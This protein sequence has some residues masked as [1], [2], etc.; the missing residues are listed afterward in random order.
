MCPACGTNMERPLRNCPNPQS[1]VKYVRATLAAEQEGTCRV[2][3]EVVRQ[4][5]SAS[6]G[7]GTHFMYSFEAG[8]GTPKRKHSGRGDLE[9]VT[10]ATCVPPAVIRLMEPCFVNPN[11]FEA[12]KVLLSHLGKLAGVKQCG[13]SERD[14]LVITCD[15]LPYSL[16]RTVMH[17]A[18]L[19][20]IKQALAA[21]GVP[22]YESMSKV[23]LQSECSRRGLSRQGTV[24]VI[25]ERLRCHVDKELASGASPVPDQVSGN[26]DWVVCTGK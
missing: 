11:S 21:A 9:D 19:E 17:Q 14:W 18:R 10:E 12:I 6:I 24:D 8:T 4:A 7:P 20:E 22:H 15:G 2:S 25:R 26:F 1:S 5:R 23:Q 16:L 13:G 3:T